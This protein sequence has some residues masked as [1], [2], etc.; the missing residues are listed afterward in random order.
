MYVDASLV[1]ANV[2]GYDLAPSGMSVAEFKERSIE[3][4]GLFVLTE[5]TVD[6]D[7]V[8][9]DEVRYFQSPEGRMPLNP[10]DTDARWKTT[11]AGKASGLQHQENVIVDL[12]GF[13]LSRRVT[14]ASERESK[15]AADLLEGLPLQPVSLAGDT[16]YSDGRLRYLLEE[17]DITAYIPIH[18]RQETSMVASGDFVHHGDHL[19]CPQGKTLRRGAYHKRQRAYMYVA[20]QKDCQACPI[21]ETCLPPGQ[22]RR[23]FSVTIYHSVDSRARERNRTAAYQRERFRRRTIAEGTF[24]SLDWLGWDKSRLRGLWK[25]DCEGYVAALAHNVKKMVRRLRG[26]VGPP[27]P[28]VPA[29]AIAQD[30]SCD[31]ADAAALFTA[32]SSYS[33]RIIWW[34]VDTRLAPRWIH[35][36]FGDFLN[37]PLPWSFTRRHRLGRIVSTMRCTDAG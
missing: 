28:V 9:H 8:E 26:G 20:R 4:N 13:I 21:K 1:K 27:G 29:D 2:S 10:V 31:V 33:G 30:A 11:R 16:G 24:A 7:G 12:G 19:I 23:F 25:V 17:R 18:P 15:A 22:K 3:E 34:T 14:H 37:G 36:H 5:T 32:L 6:D 35:C